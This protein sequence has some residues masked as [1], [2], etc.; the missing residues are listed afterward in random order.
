MKDFQS[1]LCM[2]LLEEY[3]GAIV[4][5]IGNSLLYGTKTLD[6]IRRHTDLPLIKVNF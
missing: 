4:Q 6:V 5:C 3:F 2:L 1:K